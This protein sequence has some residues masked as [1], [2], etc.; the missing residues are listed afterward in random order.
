MAG[1]V[2]S[3]ESAMKSMNLEKV[4]QEMIND[5]AQV[6]SNPRSHPNQLKLAATKLANKY[7]TEKIDCKLSELLFLKRWPLS[8]ISQHYENTPM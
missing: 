2:K 6:L 3:M 5:Q 7:D 8:F 4:G 1:V